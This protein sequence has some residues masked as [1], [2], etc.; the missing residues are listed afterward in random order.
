MRKY[1]KKLPESLSKD[2]DDS[3]EGFSPVRPARL[4][5]FVLDALLDHGKKVWEDHDARYKKMRSKNPG[6]RSDPDLLRRY[7]EATSGFTNAPYSEELE[8]LKKHVQKCRSDWAGLGKFARTPA[9]PN[10]KARADT[11]QKQGLVVANI[12]KEYA[13]GPPPES[14]VNLYSLP[15]GSRMVKEIKASFAYSLG[16]KFAS[17]V[18]FHDICSLKAGANCDEYP[19]HGRFKD[20]TVVSHSVARRYKAHKAS[21]EAE[22]R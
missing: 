11:K 3:K 16:E 22:R 4:G 8:I 20:I 18:A 21:S 19:V 15:G 1:N 5:K 13:V 7:E 12:K 14:I 6:G 17:E 2:G 9:S 10:A